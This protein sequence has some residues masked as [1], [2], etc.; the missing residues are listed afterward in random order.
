M[1]VKR[2]TT[3]EKS[4]NLRNAGGGRNGE[5]LG[6]STNMS[7][8]TFR[9]RKRKSGRAEIPGAQRLKEL[10]KRN[11]ELKGMLAGSLL[12]RRVLR[13]VNAKKQ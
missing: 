11:R 7:E 10:K 5:G 9:R 12:K 13:I 3:D 1:R 6:Q 2:C 4:R 8:Q